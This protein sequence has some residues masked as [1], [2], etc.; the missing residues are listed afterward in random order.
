VH[1]ADETSDDG[2]THAVQARKALSLAEAFADL[3]GNDRRPLL[4]LR[5]CL[6]CNGT[7][8]ALMTRQA[9][10]ERTMLMSRWFHCIK[11]SPDVLEPD[12]PYHALFAQE[13]PGHLFLS[14]WKGAGRVDLSG[15]QSRTELWDLMEERLAAEYRQKPDPLLRKLQK[16]LDGLDEVDRDLALV[17]DQIDDAV[18]KS[19]SGGSKL[20]K[21]QKRLEGLQREK[22]ALREQAREL[23]K[24]EFVPDPPAA[25]GT[26]R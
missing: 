20:A 3:A 15:E 8:N 9:D 25:P 4:V 7:D 5:E 16:L 26:E 19:G 10:N 14:S 24:L 17:K 12:H 18:E 11:L 1:A 22:S 21:L 13:N 6:V 23:S 2:L